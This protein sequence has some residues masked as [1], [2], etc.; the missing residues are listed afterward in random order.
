MAAAERDDADALCDRV[1]AGLYEELQRADGRTLVAR[2]IVSGATAAHTAV[3]RDPERW[4]H[5]IRALAAE[6]DQLWVESVRFGTRQHISAEQLVKRGDAVGQVVRALQE[7]AGSDEA[8]RLLLTHFEDL[9]SKLPVEV[10]QGEDGI[11]LDDPA[12][13][14][15]VL[16]DVERMLI[17]GLIDQDDRGG[18]G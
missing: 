16:E 17:V 5:Q 1:R 6:L 12:E 9:A 11:R 4:S 10:R 15:A 3:Q 13:L 18:A 8:K 2:V 7:V 14:D